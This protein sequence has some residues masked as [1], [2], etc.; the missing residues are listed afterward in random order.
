MPLRRP[1][2]GRKK[3]ETQ[4][5]RLL[6]RPDYQRRLRIYARAQ[7]H[8]MHQVSAIALSISNMIQQLGILYLATQRTQ[9]PTLSLGSASSGQVADEEKAIL[10]AAEAGVLW[11]HLQTVDRQLW[12]HTSS[13]DWWER[14][15]LSTWEDKQ[16]LETFRMSRATF[17]HI[18]TK[19]SPYITRQNTVMRR[20]LSPEKRVAI[21][22]LRLA[23]PTSLR[24][25][26]NQ[27]G[28]GMATAGVAVREVCRLL[29]N[30]MANSFICLEN[31]QEVIDG[32]CSMGFPNCVGAL[33]STH[34]PVR[35]Q[36]SQTNVNRKG[37]ASIILQAVVDHHGR[38]TNIF[39][40]WEGSV[41]DAEVLQSSPLP[42]LME[43]GKYAPEI[44]EVDIRGIVTS[45]VLIADPAY[46][47]LPW[48]MKPYGGELDHR[49]EQFNDCLNKCRATLEGAFER[50]RARW[51][52][53]SVPLE[54]DKENIKR[55]IVAACVL[56][57]MCESR[58]EVF[59]ESWTEEVRR[60]EKNPQRK[61]AQGKES[62]VCDSPCIEE[63]PEDE[64]ASRIRDALADHLL[65]TLHN[66]E[67]E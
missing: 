44:P 25:I 9:C 62:E 13:T 54:M 16:W 39:T 21:A 59:S 45:P 6:A 19:L 64:D 23:T 7:L 26:S 51:Q 34:I 36:G 41:R 52:A 35:A 55:V 17:M 18:V 47:L 15:V 32:F 61:V 31:P 24:L 63:G 20:P 57:N 66:E 49:Q 42:D 48:L 30:V 28:V 65:A 22:V 50:L 4:R 67:G 1:M 43:S 33:G 46:P 53:L 5:S 27:F 14:I 29:H 8:L 38:F 37:P 56:H 60:S 58:G 40:E 10:D 12:A 2:T 3:Q 11:H